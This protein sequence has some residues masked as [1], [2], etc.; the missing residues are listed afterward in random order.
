MAL[1]GDIVGVV[2]SFAGLGVLSVLQ[3]LIIYNWPAS[4]LGKFLAWSSPTQIELGGFSA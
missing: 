4:K 2:V 1:W 3:K